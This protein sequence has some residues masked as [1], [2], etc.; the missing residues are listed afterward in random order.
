MLRLAKLV[1]IFTEPKRFVAGIYRYFDWLFLDKIFFLITFLVFSL[2]PQYLYIIYNKKFPRD[3]RFPLFTKKERWIKK[4]NPEDEWFYKNKNII[5]NEINIICRGNYRKYLKKIN[6]NL[7]TF[8]VSFNYN[9]NI[10][11]PYT[12]ITSQGS[13]KKYHLWQIKIFKKGLYPVIVWQHGKMSKKNKIRWKKVRKPYPNANELKKIDGH[14]PE[15]L[16][17]T[18]KIYERKKLKF[19]K[20]NYKIC[21]LLSKKALVHFRDFNSSKN[22]GTALGTIILL[23][24]SSKKVNIYGWDAWLKKGVDKYSYWKLIKTISESSKGKGSIGGAFYSVSLKGRWGER[25]DAHFSQGILSMHYAA[26]LIEQKKYKIFSRLSKIHKQKKFLK[27][28]DKIF[29]KN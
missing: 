2:C 18:Y 29:F 9:P 5:F 13:R 17:G 28:I 27:N 20:I 1:L 22:W 25:C 7:P 14:L 4:N 11:I 12:C 15:E 16:K 3:I 24:A 21:K 8:F 6:K 10:N 23:G 26:R 19:N